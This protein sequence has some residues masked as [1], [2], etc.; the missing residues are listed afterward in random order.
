[1]KNPLSC[2]F[3]AILLSSCSQSAMDIEYVPVKAGNS[4]L[5]QKMINEF[6][7][8]GIDYR[9]TKDGGLEADLARAQDISDIGNRVFAT[10]LPKGR[11]FSVNPDVLA[12]FRAQL[13][14]ESIAYRSLHVSGLEWTIV[15][16][17]DVARS[18]EIADLVFEEY[19]DNQFPSDA[20]SQPDGNQ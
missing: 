20:A 6:E 3:I 19:L 16:E 7:R 2:L 11:S 13:D 14:V 4:E 17:R 5:Q 12:T 8:G 10:Y 18:K 15:D 9:R 1:M